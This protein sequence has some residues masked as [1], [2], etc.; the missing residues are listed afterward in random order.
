MIIINSRQLS[1][2]LFACLGEQHSS[3]SI[4]FIVHTLGEQHQP[5]SKQLQGHYTETHVKTLIF[6]HSGI[7]NLAG[8]HLNIFAWVVK[9]GN[10]RRIQP[11]ACNTAY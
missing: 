5:N 1:F 6:S 3:S 10:L 8:K 11:G 2:H 7:M 4:L 9:I